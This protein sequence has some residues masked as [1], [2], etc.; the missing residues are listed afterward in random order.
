MATIKTEQN[1]PVPTKNISNTLEDFKKLVR[2]AIFLN[3]EEESYF[4]AIPDDKWSSIFIKNFDANLGYAS[5]VLLNKFSDIEAN[6]TKKVDQYKQKIHNLDKAV[7]MVTTAIDDKTPIFFL[8]D[9]DNDGSLAQAIIYEYLKIDQ[10]AS[11]KMHVEYAQVVNGNANR[12]FTVD[13][14]EKIIDKKKMDI[15][16]KFLIVTADNGINSREEQLKIQKQFPNAQILV[17]DHHNPEPDMVIIENENVLI[18]NPHYKPTPFFEKYNISGAATIGVLLKNVLNHRYTENQLKPFSQH[19]RNIN[20]ISKVSNVID[21]VDSHPADKPEKDYVVSRFL[22]L[23]PLL[24][25]NNSITKLITGEVS[26]KTIAALSTKIP[27]LDVQLLLDETKNIK[28][29]NIIASYLLK[30]YKNNKNDVTLTGDSFNN[31]FLEEIA[32]PQNYEEFINNSNTIDENY[33]GQLRPIIF[34]LTADDEKLPFLNAL[35]EKMIDTFENVKISEQKIGQELR[36]GEVVTK[37]KLPNSVIAYAD[38]NILTIFNRKFLNKVY[39]D[40]NPGFSLTLDNVDKNKVSG[41]FR[42]LYNISEILRDKKNLEKKLNIKIETPGHEKAAG[43]IIKTTDSNKHPVTA[44]TI[45]AIN[46]HINESIAKIKLNE[47]IKNESYLLTD[48]ENIHII[49]RINK[50]VRGSVAN[51]ERLTPIIKLTPNTIWTDSYTTQQ[52][53]ME[54]IT[55]DKKYGYITI[56]TNFHGDTVIIPVELV[57]RIVENNYEDYMSLNYM[58]GGVFMAE[59]VVAHKDVHNVID[60]QKK[61]GKSQDIINTFNTHFKN[62]SVVE[63]TREQLKDNPFFKY[64]D[65]GDLNFDLFEKMV[66]GIIDTNKIDTLAVFDVEANGFGNARL[67]NFGATNYSIDE[68]SG[69][70]MNRKEFYDKFYYSGRGEEY[71]LT[72]TQTE[73][74]KEITRDE[75]LKLPLDL[76]QQV[77]TKYNPGRRETYRYFLYPTEKQKKVRN[78]H[79]LPFLQISNYIEND[80]GQLSEVTYNRTI[81]AN[82]LAYL[83]RDK[84]YKSGQEIINLTG[85][86][87]EIL[88]NQGKDTAIVDQEL[89]D[90]YKGKKVLFGAHNTPY[91]SKVI[92]AN[93]PQMYSIL[94]ENYIYDSA[95]FSKKQKLAY[96]F[97]QAA[98]FE[99][100]EGIDK[101]VYFYHNDHSDFNI[102]KVLN[103]GV[104]GYYPDRSGRYLLEIKNGEYFIVDKEMHDKVKLKSKAKDIITKLNIGQLFK[105][106]NEQYVLKNKKDLTIVSPG[107]PLQKILDKADLGKF[108]GLYEL[109]D[110]NHILVEREIN[111]EIEK[112]G[113][114][115]TQ[116]VPRYSIL[117]LETKEVTSVTSFHQELLESLKVGPLP[118][119][120]VKYSVEK[121]SEQWMIRALLLNDEKFNVN[122]VDLNQLEKDGEYKYNL[123]KNKAIELQFFQESYHFDTSAKDN[124]ALFKQYLAEKNLEKLPTLNSQN[125]MQ[126]GTLSEAKEALIEEHISLNL[127]STVNIIN[128]KAER[129]FTNEEI[130]SNED[131][132]NNAEVFLNST[133]ENEELELFIHEFLTLNS[134]IQKKFSDAW[135]YKKVLEIK[136]P[137]RI[138]VTLDLI[139]LVNYQTNIPIDKIVII[140]DEAIKFKEKYKINH[141]IQHEQHVNGLF[142]GDTKGD[143]LFE[144]KLTLSL[145]AQRMYDAYN[146]D[147]GPAIKLFNR[148]QMDARKAF[149]LSHYLSDGIANDSYSFRQ[150]I[151]YNRDVKT[152]LVAG[153]QNKEAAAGKINEEQIIKFKL[154]ND[155]LA[156]DNAVYAISRVG[157]VITREDIEGDKNKLSFIMLNSQIKNS[158]ELIHE[159][160][161]KAAVEQILDSNQEI[162][163]QYK[164]S[165]AKRYRYIEFN[166]RDFN[167]KKIVDIFLK[168]LTGELTLEERLEYETRRNKG[169]APN[170]QNLIGLSSYVI[171]GLKDRVGIPLESVDAKGFD[172][173]KAVVL[174]YISNFKRLNPKDVLENEQGLIAIM[175]ETQNSIMPTTL[176]LALKDKTKSFSDFTK[177]EEVNFMYLVEDKKL[178][179]KTKP[180]EAIINKFREHRFVNQLV[181]NMKLDAIDE[182]ERKKNLVVV[183]AHELNKKVKP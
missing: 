154:D 8:T 55:K 124:L 108:D 96:D 109:E 168:V 140:F 58:D 113:Q 126:N 155:I 97:I 164:T 45:E 146:H 156:Q 62:K 153:I 84:D 142:E 99:G 25:I 147:E 74:L 41:S 95:L 163:N 53:S 20:K 87:Q 9:I 3:A 61:D 162:I 119:T 139:E 125:I 130:D 21:Y 107:K 4:L 65:F 46:A 161:V 106:D 157:G 115:S 173:A 160:S 100:V 123:I 101:S 165:L 82:M 69:S 7:K 98:R 38:P 28:A 137:K 118:D 120:A 150:G 93:M 15:N 134:A 19:I 122:Y 75:K 67:M 169:V 105:I 180:L 73:E 143:V 102:K 56:N 23:Q 181:E 48:L 116:K 81:K 66:I 40:E 149:D 159:V 5:R 151:L 52:Y 33:I 141:I 176:E 78:K 177:T 136:D 34:N 148:E 70:V 183:G 121:L 172:V 112:N 89:F 47:V 10:S 128:N 68:K 24:N 179:K 104:D 152:D 79:R 71:L 90:F 42:S 138:E 27:K 83:V 6:D 49:D 2:K 44:Q 26:D 129:E 88:E 170:P 145:L 17:T 85:I 133:E 1:A 39:N 72:T 103:A 11:K 37:T 12:G 59:R 57:R 158:L 117:N 14:V 63:F 167:V 171:I 166:K 31:K 35:N 175:N 91:D 60:L 43:F 94:R 64:N 174:N 13:L 77:L 16:D 50:V 114:K 76:S 135:M 32:N 111:I 182:M 92:R 86:T 132:S 29:Q 36:R 127:K 131:D 144:D 80:S 22:K 30:I 110:P 18:F 51:F 54:D 178:T